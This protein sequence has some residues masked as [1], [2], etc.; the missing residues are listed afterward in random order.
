MSPGCATAADAGL[1]GDGAIVAMA[2]ADVAPYDTVARLH[3][4]PQDVGPF[5]VDGFDEAARFMAGDDG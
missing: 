5:S 1:E 2:T 4:F 3:R